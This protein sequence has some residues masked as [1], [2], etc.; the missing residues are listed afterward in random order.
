MK[1]TSSFKI[2]LTALIAALICVATMLI[3]VPIPATGG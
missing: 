1:N 2:V 3:Q